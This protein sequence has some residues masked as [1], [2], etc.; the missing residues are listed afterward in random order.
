[1][2]QGVKVLIMGS[3]IV[4][5]TRLYLCQDGRYSTVPREMYGSHTFEYI[6]NIKNG[7]EVDAGQTY[8]IYEIS[9][10]DKTYKIG[11]LVRSTNPNSG[12][13]EYLPITKFLLS[14]QGNLVA[15][16]NAFK[17]HGLDVLKMEDCIPKKVLEVD[18]HEV[19]YKVGD[20]TLFDGAPMQIT[21]F[22]D[23]GGVIIVYLEDPKYPGSGTSILADNLQGNI[24]D[25]NKADPPRSFNEVNP[26]LIT[27]DGANIFEG[28]SVF[29][30]NPDFSIKEV[31]IDNKNTEDG[32]NCF[33]TEDSALEYVIRSVPVLTYQDIVDLEVTARVKKLEEIKELIKQRYH[34]QK[35]IS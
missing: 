26:I 10:G 21:K 20:F 18:M 35:K 32:H 6:Y 12:N 33:S 1:M 30:V 13:K 31:V 27:S 4:G 5:K 8:P 16:T 3:E 34:G 22:E 25:P 7:R 14:P 29:I 15:F 9:V 19:H 24:D 28:N 17:E 23:Q 11:S 2:Q